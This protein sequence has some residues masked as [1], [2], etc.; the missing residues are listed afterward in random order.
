M[1]V[2]ICNT[3]KPVEGAIRGGAKGYVEVST[4]TYIHFH[5]SKHTYIQYWQGVAEGVVS[6]FA[7]PLKGGEILCERVAEGAA[8]SAGM[9]GHDNLTSHHVSRITKLKR[10]DD[11]EH[12]IRTEADIDN[13]LCRVHLYNLKCM[14]VYVRMCVY[15]C[16]YVCMY[17]CRFYANGRAEKL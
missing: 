15:V 1:C 14:Y 11:E 4:Y 10:G 12:T 8:A 16:M 17:V 7:R 2:C 5:P 13:G 3:A 6:F 9:T